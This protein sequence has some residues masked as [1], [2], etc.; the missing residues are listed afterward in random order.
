[1]A[2]GTERPTE[3]SSIVDDVNP[4]IEK[5]FGRGFKGNYLTN[6]D[7]EGG[8]GVPSV[9]LEETDR[10]LLVARKR[11]G[12]LWR[13]CAGQ[14]GSNCGSE[15]DGSVIAVHPEYEEKAKKYVELY[16]QKFGIEARVV[17]IDRVNVM[18]PDRVPAYDS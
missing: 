13:E 8:S 9:D 4:L 3:I 12:G 18:D 10:L 7:S 16:N 1:M 5:A 15:R 11:L 14:L 17:L 6:V 2:T